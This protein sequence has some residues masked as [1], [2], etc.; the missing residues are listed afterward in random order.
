M[1]FRKTLSVL[2]LLA[3]VAMVASFR[4]SWADADRGV[5]AD[6]APVDSAVEAAP[7]PATMPPSD[8]PSIPAADQETPRSTRPANQSAPL[9]PPGN[10]PIPGPSDVPLP[11]PAAPSSPEPELKAGPSNRPGGTTFK[12]N[13][14]KE[15]PQLVTYLV[16]DSSARMVMKILKTAAPDAQITADKD[17]KHVTVVAT[18]ADHGRIRVLLTDLRGFLTHALPLPPVTSAAKSPRTTNPMPPGGDPFAAVPAASDPFAAVP[19]GDPLTAV[20]AAGDPFAAVPSG[21]AGLPW[22][23]PAGNVTRTVVLDTGNLS[24]KTLMRILKAAAPKADFTVDQDDDKSLVVS[25]PSDE[26]KKI[27]DALGNL[28]KGMSDLQVTAIM[29]MAA[30]DAALRSA[31]L[32]GQPKGP[33]TSYGSSSPA[34]YPLPP[35]TRYSPSHPSTRYAASHPQRGKPADPEMVKLEQSDASASKEVAE[36]VEECKTTTGEEQQTKV[37]WKLKQAVLEHFAVRQSKRELEVARLEARLEKV[38]QSITKRSELQ[39]QIVD[40]HVSQ[41][42]GERDDLEF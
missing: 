29:S 32:R 34:Y 2:V 22:T 18:P 12:A 30:S 13:D 40:R 6:A 33:S 37:R 25:A 39:D 5:P 35:S 28:P 17:N 21:P 36:I 10:D 8:A 31:R 41:L 38:R 27:E 3:L 15:D 7:A 23:D 26:F 19:V 16:G 20:P 14:A 11:G 4:S 24:A 42:L 9:S 1:R